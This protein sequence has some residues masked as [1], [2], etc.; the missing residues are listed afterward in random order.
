MLTTRPTADRGEAADDA[1]VQ[2]IAAALAHQ[3]GRRLDDAERDALGVG[4]EARHGLPERQGGVAV[5]AQ[6]LGDRGIAYGFAKPPN[7]QS[8]GEM[9]PICSMLGAT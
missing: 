8:Q 2:Q 6:P 9:F 5:E 4:A 1:L 3:L 7:G